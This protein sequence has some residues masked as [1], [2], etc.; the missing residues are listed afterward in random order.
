MDKTFVFN[1]S[2]GY[3]TAIGRHDKPI[4]A[5]CQTPAILILPFEACRGMGGPPAALANN[6]KTLSLKSLPLKMRIAD[7]S[8]WF[9]GENV[10]DSGGIML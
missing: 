6:A 2:G 1:N 4:E 5:S 8:F 10:A 7:V 9:S 3:T